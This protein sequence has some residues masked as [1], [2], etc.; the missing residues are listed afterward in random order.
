MGEYVDI[1]G[2]PTWVE[3]RGRGDET[4]LLLHGGLSDSD[5]LL[6]GI[7]P[8]LAER[9]RVVA[10][11]RRGHGRTA[12]TDAPFHYDDMAK[13]TVAVL[14]KVVGGPAHLVGWSDGGIIAL[15]MGIGHPEVVG[16]LV[17]IGANYHYDGLG[18]MELDP[19]SPIAKM[20]ADAYGARSP[21][22]P[23]H[24]PDVLAKAITL[25]TAE[26]TLTT[27]DLARI[28]APTLVLAGDDELIR[29]DHTCSLYEALP[30]GQLAIVPGASHAVPIEKPA[31]VLH[32]ILDFL[33]GP[34][35]PPTV[36]AVRRQPTT[37]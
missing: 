17:A 2:H 12:D 7:G 28:T 1:L 23:E 13:E 5:L 19:E 24:F 18:T 29:L 8:G 14:D 9:Y 27:A 33:T 6:D 21:D 31:E 11:D 37:A 10:F 35:S 25:F 36:M 20:I 3:D 15:L 22:G 16:R 32:L 26:P 34:E 30:A 4:V